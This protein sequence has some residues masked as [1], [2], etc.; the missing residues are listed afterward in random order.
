MRRP[1]SS[2]SALLVRWLDELGRI[3]EERDQ[4]TR[5]FLSPA[6]RRANDRVAGWMRE[7]GLTVREDRFGNIAGRI[8]SSRPGA[9]VL[10]LGSHLD[11]VRD[12]GKF[13]GALGVL[14]P[15][16]ALIELCRRGVSLPYA[17]EVIGFSE[18]EGVRFPTAYLGSKAFTGQL[19]AADLN[20]RNANGVSVREAL[21]RWSG[22]TP[23]RRT[24]VAERVSVSRECFTASTTP[25]LGVKSLPR[26][27]NLIGYVEVHLEQG[28]VLE[29]ENLPVGVVSAIAGQTRG[30]WT[31]RGRA[32]HAGT[33]PM[34]LRRDALAGAA[35]FLTVAEGLA[36]AS[37][38]LVVTAGSL[39]VKPGAPNVIPGEVVFSLDVR[40]PRNA[41]RRAALRL[42]R[43]AAQKIAH[44]RKLTC[45]WEQTQDNGAVACSPKLMT[46]LEESVR[47]VHGRSLQ[48][49]SGAGHDAVIMSAK[50]PVGMLFVRCRD[51]LSHH[52]DE[53]ASAA[54]VDV[55]LQVMVDFLERLASPPRVARTTT[56]T[57]K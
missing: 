20:L 17:V 42:L 22:L 11:T 1:S 27:E 18:E 31:F 29:R 43:L 6:M 12:A 37:E 3:S 47:K 4:L 13:D 25:R 33:T 10:F 21:Q 38:P 56:A 55:A 51:G 45:A 57:R 39:S 16:A 49:M 8:E 40:H 7:A 50:M 30:R 15:I 35:E 41:S 26:R 23:S 54:D 24:G 34:H 2:C 48:L 36:R 52:P 19:R 5:T 46:L 14:L 53:H 32:G 44:N 28:P 9:P